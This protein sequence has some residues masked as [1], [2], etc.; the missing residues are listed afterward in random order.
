VRVFRLRVDE[1]LPTDDVIRLVAHHYARSAEEAK[2]RRY[3]L[4]AGRIAIARGRR[5]PVV[6]A[7]SAGC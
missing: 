7:A 5:V 6:V 2:A 3:L 4:A 1:G